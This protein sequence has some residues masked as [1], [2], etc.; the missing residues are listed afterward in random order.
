MP[1]PSPGMFPSPMLHPNFHSHSYPHSHSPSPFRRA[2]T[3][4]PADELAGPLT[5]GHPTPPPGSGQFPFDLGI[6][7]SPSPANVNP[8]PLKGPPTPA[9]LRRMS[10]ESS[11]L[12]KK[13]QQPRSDR[14][15]SGE[16]SNRGSDP[17]P[18]IDETTSV[19]GLGMGEV[20]GS[21]SIETAASI[22]GES[23][24]ASHGRD[25]GA[26]EENESIPSSSHQSSPSPPNRRSMLLTPAPADVFHGALVQGTDTPDAFDQQQREGMSGITDIKVIADGERGN[27]YYRE[28]GDRSS[29][30]SDSAHANGQNGHSNGA[31]GHANGH[32]HDADHVSLND[33]DEEE[34]VDADAAG[35][36]RLKEDYV[37]MFASLA[38]TPQQLAEIQRMRE[39]A[40]KAK[41]REAAGRAPVTPGA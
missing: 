27:L 30:S 37:P 10:I 6:M 21:S 8:S 28:M 13:V 24:T 25:S 16:E 23:G 35:D 38:H 31:N 32:S 12:K 15:E 3:S 7:P 19:Q 2:S 1:F 26:G 18:D 36:S 40:I 29:F 9:D 39:G 33:E 4:G 11:V 14:S 20:G 41:Q 34:L 22:N 5:P 17:L